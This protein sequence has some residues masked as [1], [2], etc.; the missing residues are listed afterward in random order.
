MI[1]IGN[2]FDVHAFAS[3]RRLILGGVHIPHPYGLIGHSDADVLTHAICDALLGALALGDIGQFFPDDDPAYKDADSLDLL[4]QVYRHLEKKSATVINIDSTLAL[5][6]PK[7]A[8]FIDEMRH[9]IASN[10]NC[11]IAQIGIK[12]TTTERLGFVG[13]KEGVAAFAVALLELPDL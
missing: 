1:R 11:Q 6:T 2:G 3:E 10:L 7:L 9:N 5:Q 8:S 4:R 12:A 13:R